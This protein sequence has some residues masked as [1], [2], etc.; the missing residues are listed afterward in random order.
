M[1]KNNR[2]LNSLFD[3]I[4]ERLP[5]FLLGLV[6]LILLVFIAVRYSQPTKPTQTPQQPEVK[7]T[8]T[9]EKLKNFF[10]GKKQEDKTEEETNVY[11]VK[12][13]DHLWK[14]SEDKYGSGYNAYDIAKANKITDPN[15]IEVGQKISLPQLTPGA[16][17]RG[18]TMEKMTEK[19][20]PQLKEYTIK[21][22]DYLWKIAQ[23]TY[24]DPYMWVK[25]AQTNNLPNPDLLYVGTKL[26][27]P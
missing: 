2:N 22:G 18:E 12:A 20:T 1:T 27:L 9:L 21:Q 24:G 7:K 19:A 14:I 16:P 26:T 4:Q 15:L 8:S 11:V 5:S 17:T 23:E 10:A 6:V 3:T 25:I 13:G